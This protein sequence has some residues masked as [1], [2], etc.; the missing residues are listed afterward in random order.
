[1]DDTIWMKPKHI[2]KKAVVNPADLAVTQYSAPFL[3][4]AAS[5]PKIS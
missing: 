1:M 4:A 3:E 2:P 5:F